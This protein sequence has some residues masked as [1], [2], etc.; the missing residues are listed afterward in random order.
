MKNEDKKN[1]ILEVARDCFARFG[2]DKTTLDDIGKAARLNKA[3]LYYYFKNKEEIFLQVVLQES[4]QYIDDLQHKVSHLQSP[5]DKILQ[6]LIERL[7]YYKQVINLHQLSIESLHHIEPIFHQFYQS[8]LEKEKVFIE[9][10]LQKGVE[11]KQLYEHNSEQLA[12]AIITLADAL[13]RDAG[14]GQSSGMVNDLDYTETEQHIQLLVGL[15]LKG[16]TNY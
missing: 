7:R 9:K 3:S 8:V 12:F 15:I 16:I 13:K 11:E 10:V 5:N 1:R 6:Y 4:S 14:F 2:F